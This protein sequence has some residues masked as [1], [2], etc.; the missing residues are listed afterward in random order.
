MSKPSFMILMT[1]AAAVCIAGLDARE[2]Q[3]GLPQQSAPSPQVRAG[4]QP[5]SGAGAVVAR[6]RAGTAA[7]NGYS[8][9]EYT[10]LLRR[11]RPLQPQAFGA[12]SGSRLQLEARLTRGNIDPMEGSVWPL[13]KDVIYGDTAALEARFDAGESPDAFFF[14]GYP[15]N[16]N[17]SLLDIAIEAGQRDVIRLLLSRGASVNPTDAVAADGTRAG[18]EA[19]VP[20]A[21]SYGED[22]VIRAL[23]RKGANIDQILHYPHNQ[24]TALRAAVYASDV[25]TVYLLLTHGADVDLALGPGRTVPEI[26]RQGP[27]IPPRLVAIRNLLV[28]YGATMPPGR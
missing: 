8:E 15:L 22:D 7:R 12:L 3:S 19:P 23:L 27:M 16:S 28:E 21:A 20:L 4:N 26:L 13:A 17:I 24:E 2:L 25:S 10:L 5:G 6:P 11:Y 18:P 14:M 1:L 9:R